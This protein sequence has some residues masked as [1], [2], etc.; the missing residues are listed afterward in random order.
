MNS[1]PTQQSNIRVWIF[2]DM[3]T[4]ARE[5]VEF[6]NRQGGIIGVPFERP[7][8]CLDAVR[9]KIGE[10]DVVLI[11]KDLGQYCPDEQSLRITSNRLVEM[12][13]QEAPHIRIGIV[14]GEYPGGQKHVLEMGADFYIDVLDMTNGWTVNELRKGMVS[15]KEQ[16]RRGKTVERPPIKERWHGIEG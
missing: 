9:T 15:P 6:L 8:Q 13:H 10:C 2:H 11:H 1:T 5:Y 14:S 4:K 3:E 12:I 16:E 7:S